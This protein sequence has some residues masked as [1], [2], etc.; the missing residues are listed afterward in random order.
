M[1]LFLIRDDGYG[2]DEA[3]AGNPLSAGEVCESVPCSRRLSQLQ[4][5]SETIYI[6]PQEP[7][8][9]EPT[10]SFH[11]SVLPSCS[12]SSILPALMWFPRIWNQRKRR[13]GFSSTLCSEDAAAVAPQTKEDFFFF[14]LELGFTGILL[15]FSGY[16]TL[17]PDFRN[18]AGFIP[19]VHLAENPKESVWSGELGLNHLSISVKHTSQIS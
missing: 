7:P 17:T 16:T 19:L 4:H 11:L 8:T 13:V 15:Y 3:A 1:S 12:H 5:L 2:R 9:K 6:F 14:F 18:P 10:L